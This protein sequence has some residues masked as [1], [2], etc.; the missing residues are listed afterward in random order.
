MLI[1]WAR[2]WSA[3]SDDVTGYSDCIE[4]YLDASAD[5]ALYASTKCD[6]ACGLNGML[7]GVA[8]FVG[9]KWSFFHVKLQWQLGVQSLCAETGDYFNY[10]C[11][12]AVRDFISALCYVDCILGGYTFIWSQYAV[13]V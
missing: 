7:L 13:H 4:G 9:E 6:V 3:D 2:G 12:S 8:L 1:C 5:A 10:S 11:G